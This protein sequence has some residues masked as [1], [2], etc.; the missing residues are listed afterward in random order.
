MITA[1]LLLAYLISTANIVGIDVDTSKVDPEQAYCLAENIYYEARN[2]DIRGQFAVASVTLNRANDGRFP[3]TVCAVVK[4]TAVSRI[5]KQLVCAFSWYCENDKK[6]REIPVRNK[7]GTINQRVVDQFQVASI[8]A[9]TV[10]GGDVEDNTN[11]ATHFHNPHTSNPAWKHELIKTM[12]VGNHDFY[13]LY[14]AKE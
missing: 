10:L 3:N 5:S 11:G 4:Q 6:G 13:K 8:V 12:S 14:P 7:D 1:K 9:I 2:E